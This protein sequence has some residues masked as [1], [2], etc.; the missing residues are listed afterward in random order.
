MSEGAQFTRVNGGIISDQMLKGNLRFFSMKGTG[1]FANT[2]S[3]GGVFILGVMPRFGGSADKVGAG[4]PVPRSAAEIAFQL[5]TTK[6]SLSQIILIGDDEIQFVA[7]NDTFGWFDPMGTVT[8]A[9]YMTSGLHLLG[10]MAVPS[11]IDNNGTIVDFTSV[12]ITE[13]HKFKLV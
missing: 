7:E 2:I 5:I 9:A 1:V 4:K 3:D 6:C 10:S 8:D 13:F 12:T 11:K